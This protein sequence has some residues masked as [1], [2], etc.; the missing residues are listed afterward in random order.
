M[1]YSLSRELRAFACAL[2]ICTFGTSTAWAQ[3]ADILS[4]QDS[5]V[6]SDARSMAGFRRGSVRASLDAMLSARGMDARTLATLSETANFT[7]GQ[8]RRFARYEQK[9]DGLRV[10]GAY[11]KAAF[12]SAGT[13]IHLIERLAPTGPARARPSI[14]EAAALRVALATNFPGQSAPPALSVVGA[15]TKFADTDF[16][17]Q[18]P[19][20]E[21]VVIA[22]GRAHEEGFLVE[23]WSQA[24][25]QL[26][27]T[28]VNGFG[29][30]VSNELRTAADSYNVFAVD[31]S[32]SA[33]A[34]VNGPAPG[35]TLSP[36][37]WLGTGTQTTI[38]ISG[39]NVRAYLDRDNNN[40]ADAGGSVVTSGNFLT[41]ANLTQAPTTLSNQ[42]VAVQNLFY[43]NNVIHDR[44]YTHGFVENQGNFQENNFG[45][46][47]LGLDS[48][49]A[50]AQDGGSTNNANFATPAEGSR[51]RMQMY[52]WTLTNPQRD[53]DVDSDVVYHEYGH[54]LSTRMIGG[55]SGDI[56]GAIGEGA[57]DVLAI[58]INNNDVV[59]EYSTNNVSGIRSAPYANHPDT[60]ASFNR[61][62][63]VHRNGELFAATIWD[64]WE[65]YQ[66]NGLSVNTLL[67]D[68]VGGMNFTPSSPTYITMRDGLLAQTPA[69]RDCLVWRAFASRGM[70]VGASISRTNFRVVQSFSVPTGC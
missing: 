48:V 1:K 68:F 36:N 16:F 22:R 31:P 67:T 59:G 29:R 63:G 56:G 58:L 35:G 21:R 13:P 3:D 32:R 26:Y 51:P 5:A 69:S 30:V 20:V 61:A 66:A 7:D 55:L 44:L 65:L 8:G 10:Y 37:G 11:V 39:N 2:A 38:N 12:D 50:E 27:Y 41:A 40:A 64:V 25:N 62:R 46:G 52:L 23:T 60:L 49:L 43:L 17:A 14:G 4:E 42:S 34:V 70:G 6:S 33:Q 47:G 19:S 28:L 18:G 9:I 57:S 54:G 24:D 15:V 45:R 53:G